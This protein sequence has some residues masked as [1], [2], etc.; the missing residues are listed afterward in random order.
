[1][2]IAILEA[3]GSPNKIRNEKQLYRG[4]ST[5]KILGF[6]SEKPLV[7]RFRLV[8]I[9]AVIQNPLVR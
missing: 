2:S 6:H 4:S 1:M 3:T 5:L 8:S 9:G 7:I